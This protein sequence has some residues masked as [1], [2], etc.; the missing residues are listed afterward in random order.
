MP[1]QGY[2]TLKGQTSGNIMGSVTQ[3]DHVD[4]IAFITFDHEVLSP[5]DTATGLPTGRRMHKPVVITKEI[6][7]STPLLY[8]VLTTNERLTEVCFYFWRPTSTGQ[9]KMYYKII[10][11]NANVSSART[12]FPNTRIPLNMPLGHMEEVA[13]TYQK[14]EWTWEDGGVTAEDDWEARA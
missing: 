8:K 5:R 10:L 3:K 13:F 6:D 11:T 9:E 7:K 4:Q 2:M 1:M 12:F 14:I